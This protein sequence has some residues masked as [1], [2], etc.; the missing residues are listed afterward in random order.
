MFTDRFIKIPIKVY[1]T[2]EADLT[3]NKEYEDSW[4]KF[5]PLEIAYYK[6]SNDNET[7]EECTYIMLKSGIGMF[8]YLLPGEL[9]KLLNDQQK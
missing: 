5:N 2:E 3:G 7:N 4:M 8:V 1:D 9:E 6:P